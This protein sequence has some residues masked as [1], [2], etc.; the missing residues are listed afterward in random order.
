MKFH[1]IE[2]ALRDGTE[3]LLYGV[4]EDGTP[5]WEVG[6]WGESHRDIAEWMEGRDLAPLTPT[7]YAVLEQP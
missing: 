1:P 2:H 3:Y 4:F 5:W 6:Y 7:H